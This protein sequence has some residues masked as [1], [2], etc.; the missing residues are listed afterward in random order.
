MTRCDIQIKRKGITVKSFI[1]SIAAC[2]FII[3][4]STKEEIEALNEKNLSSNGELVGHLPDGRE[5]RR[6]QL[7][8]QHM[9]DHYV[10]FVDGDISV[11][12]NPTGKYNK[13]EVFIDG[14]K[15]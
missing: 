14:V 15:Q 5:I 12:S 7:R 6:Y 11:N 9:H 3:G 10:Y 8:F 4:C 1:L 2:L 13:V